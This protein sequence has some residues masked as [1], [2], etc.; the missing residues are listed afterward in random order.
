MNLLLEII[1]ERLDW[2]GYGISS[3]NRTAAFIACA[4]FAVWVFAAVF[5]KA[6][7]YICVIASLVLFNFLLQ[8]Q[9]R[10][11]FV[12]LAISA[13]AFVLLR[14][15][16]RN[17]WRAFF[18]AAA[19]LVAGVMYLNS[20]LSLRM[21]NMAT[22]QSS[23]ANCRAQIYLSGLKMITDIPNGT[24]EKSPS[25]VYAN[26]Y[27]D[28]DDSAQYLSLINSHLEF[29]CG[30]NLYLKIAYVAFWVFALCISFTL[31]GN[32]F[33]VSAFATWL[34]F[35]LCASFSNVANFWV[36]W[37]MPL[38]VLVA[39]IVCNRRRLLC[40]R[41]YLSVVV[42]TLAAFSAICA[43]SIALPRQYKLKF[44][45]NGNVLCGGSDTAEYLLFAPDEKSLGLRFGR[46]L[47][48]FCKQKNITVLVCYTV[49][50]A[51]FKTA[52]ICQAKD[53]GEI[54][55]INADK[56]VLLNVPLGDEC[57]NLKLENTSVYLGMFSD[58]RNRKKWTEISEKNPG[59]SVIMLNGV[60]DYIPNWTSLFLGEYENN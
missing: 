26:W 18:I 27:Q 15:F 36:L 14:G 41:F 12:G 22:L 5:K 60:G 58:W 56:K 49:P 46:E 51:K 32:L 42:L 55:S 3:A 47:A 29:M 53:A 7:F 11:A 33:C 35:G 17:K 34:C 28:P 48:E 23:S 1:P 10:G 30:H 19:I 2:F 43:V 40:G 9:S 52:L 50:N 21:T 25:Q 20:T 31:S 44:Y 16:T 8:T 13:V 6:G 45:E 57:D 39:A 37:I 4:I 54:S 38:A 24:G 59:I